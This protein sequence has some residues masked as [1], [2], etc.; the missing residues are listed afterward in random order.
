MVEAGLGFTVSSRPDT[1]L[2]LAS[3]LNY[4]DVCV[5]VCVFLHVCV[6]AI[7]RAPNDVKCHI[8][9]LF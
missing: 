4:N 2:D 9:K 3:K 7:K 1:Q 5:S 8:L 6:C